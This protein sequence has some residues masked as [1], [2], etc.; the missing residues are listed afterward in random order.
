MPI[1]DFQCNACGEIFDDIVPFK[2]PS[3]PCTKCKNGVA[4][5]I[6]INAPKLF[7]T[8]IPDYPG[9]KKRKAGYQHT[10]HADRPAT[11]VQGKGWS[12]DDK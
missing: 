7:T 2:I 3:I 12:P 10:H 8:I 9:A 1:Y 5:K 11:K 4:T 6:Y